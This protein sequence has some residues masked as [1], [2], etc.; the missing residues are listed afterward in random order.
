MILWTARSKN[1]KNDDVPQGYI[2]RTRE[3]SKATC[4]KAK[5]PM[6]EGKNG[7]HCYAQKGTPSWAHANICKAFAKGRDYSLETALKKRNP[8]AKIVRLG[9]VGDPVGAQQETLEAYGKVKKA[10]LLFIGYT[11]AWKAMPNFHDVLLASCDTLEEADRAIQCGWKPCVVLPHD[12]QGRVFLT[13]KG[14]K[15]IV[16]PA[17][18]APGKVTC[19][20]C[21]MCDASKK[22]PVIGIPD[23]GPGRNRV[24]KYK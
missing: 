9:A 12:H 24:K 22:T 18:L 8:K 11:H 3:E 7:R 10:G 5:C 21:R 15:G 23:H 6:L 1:R 20:T 14:N 16:C 13:P 2:G 17:M 19:N 4:K